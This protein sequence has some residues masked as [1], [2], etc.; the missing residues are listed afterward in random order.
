MDCRVAVGQ[1][2]RS[3]GPRLGS[4]LWREEHA[5]GDELLKALAGLLQTEQRLRI[6]FLAH[7]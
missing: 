7:K 6:D 3:F 1:V 4:H 5:A 2:L